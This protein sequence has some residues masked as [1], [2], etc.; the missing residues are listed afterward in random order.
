MTQQPAFPAAPPMSQTHGMQAPFI[1]TAGTMNLTGFAGVA[2]YEAHDALTKT[3]VSFRA[4]DTY[5]TMANLSS[6]GRAHGNGMGAGGKSIRICEPFQQGRC[7]AGERCSDFHVFPEILGSFRQQ[8]CEWL[9]SKEHEFI[10]SPP[11]RS[12]RVFCAD[13]KEV[14]EVPIQALAFTRGLFLDPSIR[15]KRSKNRHAPTSFAM[16]ASQV[17]TACGLYANATDACKWG[18]WCNQAHVDSSWLQSRRGE[19]EHWS[20]ALERDFEHLPSGHEFRVHDPESRIILQIPRAAVTEYTRG[21]YQGT[22]QKSPSVCML[23]QRGRCTARSRCNQVHVDP[24]WLALQR[25]MGVIPSSGAAGTG[26]PASLYDAPPA[27][28]SY[29]QFGRG[30]SLEGTPYTRST[31]EQGMSEFDSTPPSVVGQSHSARTLHLRQGSSGVSPMSSAGTSPQVTYMAPPPLPS[32]GPL[33]PPP[34]VGDTI[35]ATAP[36]RLNPKARAFVPGGA[37]TPPP[38]ATTQTVPLMAPQDHTA[39]QAP[40]PNSATS[41]AASSPQ[42]SPGHATRRQQMSARLHTV[43]SIEWDPMTLHEELQ[44]ANGLGG[45][46]P[47]QRQLPNGRAPANLPFNGAGFPLPPS[48]TVPDEAKIASVL[49]GIRSSTPLSPATQMVANLV[50]S[51]AKGLPPAYHNHNRA[52]MDFN[53]GQQPSTPV[54]YS[55]FFRTPVQTPNAMHNSVTG[56]EFN[57]HGLIPEMDLLPSA[58]RMDEFLSTM[59]TGAAY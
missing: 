38:A 31:S 34:N 53:K 2:E 51:P 10:A 55:P 25:Q 29:D 15:E 18:K 37:V 50:D 27:F 41:L 19:F 56:L 46:L 16:I 36:S 13:L 28:H 7:R 43:N 24:Q 22:M 40:L 47:A 54:S 44:Q 30:M 11:N 42:A 45:Q 23:Y 20:A 26:A 4:Q 35:A 5:P 3:S 32:V 8:L 12:F 39:A 52:S 9:A 57:I 33:L 1:V 17:P 59:S 14:V 48:P 58:V 49:A 6:V 21:L